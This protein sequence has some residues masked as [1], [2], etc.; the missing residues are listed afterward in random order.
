M[1]SLVIM[2]QVEDIS[3]AW[4]C[5]R[6]LLFM[7]PLKPLTCREGAGQSPADCGAC[8]YTLTHVVNTYADEGK[9]EDIGRQVIQEA[10]LEAGR[11]DGNDESI[12]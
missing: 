1:D 7:Q 5:A 8:Y 12:K 11:N 3:K 9:A 2:I 4:P 10:A 6:P